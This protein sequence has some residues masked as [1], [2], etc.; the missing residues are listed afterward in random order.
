MLKK[1][2]MTIARHV[3]SSVWKGAINDYRIGLARKCIEALIEDGF[4][5]RPVIW[6]KAVDL[7]N[8]GWKP[9]K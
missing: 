3:A 9:G 5:N 8:A 4:T 6:R 7:L 1:V 2:R